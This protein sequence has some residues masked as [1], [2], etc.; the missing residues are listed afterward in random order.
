VKKLI[1]IILICIVFLSNTSYAQEK[2]PIDQFFE[3]AIAKE[4]TVSGMNNVT[5]KATEMWEEEMNKYYNLIM[6]ILDDKAKELLGVSQE[7]WIAHKDAE[8]KAIRN[9]YPSMG[10][11]WSNVKTYDMLNLVKGRALTLKL[12]YE[13]NKEHFDERKKYLN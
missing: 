10:T 12:Y 3:D 6:D 5:Y 7:N 9:M 4:W 8:F 11:M 1:A 13:Q 2:H